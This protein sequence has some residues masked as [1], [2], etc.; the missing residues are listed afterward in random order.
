MY[1]RYADAQGWRVS[2]VSANVAEGGRGFK[3]VI[4][5]VQHAKCLP[6]FLPTYQRA[7]RSGIMHLLRVQV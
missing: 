4:V 2:Q 7:Q 5:Q 1:Q 3:E 6:Y